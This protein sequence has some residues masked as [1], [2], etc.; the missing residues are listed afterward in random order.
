MWC[1]A[2]FNSYL[3][4]FTGVLYIAYNFLTVSRHREKV[5]DVSLGT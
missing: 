4:K 2:V 5:G 3:Y 1:K